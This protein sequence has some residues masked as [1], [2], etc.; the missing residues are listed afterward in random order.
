VAK[1]NAPLLI[2]LAFLLGAAIS[3]LVM[4]HYAHRTDEERVAHIERAR[5]ALSKGQ[6]TEPPNDN[7][8]DLVRGGLMKWPNDSD[9]TRISSDAAHELV[10]RAMAARS[11]GDVGGARDL[12]KTAHDLDL[13]DGTARLLLSQYEDEL[14]SAEDAGAL[15]GPRVTLDVPIGRARPGGRAELIARVLMGANRVDVRTPQFVITGPG[16][17]TEGLTLPAIGSGPFRA[18]FAPPREG[19]YEVQFEAN[20]EGAT[21]RADR[22][23]YV[24][25]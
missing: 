10:T 21:V 8:R 14:A 6:Y 4:Q 20:V 13:T 19:S 18:T 15:G 7:V 24:T 22:T 9:L 23:L 11:G 17:E 5:T 12:A 2:L 1:R 16:L 3:A 25:K